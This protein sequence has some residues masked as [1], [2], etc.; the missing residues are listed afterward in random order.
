[1]KKFLMFSF[2]L[3]ASFAVQAQDLPYSKYLNFTDKEFKENNFKYDEYTNIWSLRKTSGVNTAVNI[4]AI[5]ADAVEEIRPA[6]NDYSIIVQMGKDDQKSYVKVIFYNDDTYHKLLTFM[7]DNGT[8][9]IETS[10]GKLLK[11]Q[12]FYNDYS[13][14]LDMEQ[15]IISRTSSRTASSKTLKN[16]DESYNEYEFTIWTD[17]EPWSEKLEKKAAK[18]ARR[19]EKGKKKQSVNDLM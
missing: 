12:A 10:S 6:K 1:M 14:E 5:I 17:V 2:A 11:S 13:I 3:L 16:V 7:K 8:D 18:Q 9:M 19:D 4:L 15:H